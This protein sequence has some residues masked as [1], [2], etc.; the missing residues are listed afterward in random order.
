MEPESTTLST[1]GPPAPLPEE[2]ERLA[3]ARGLGS[4]E[5]GT[6]DDHPVSSALQVAVVA[7]LLLGAAAV[8]DWLA[9]SLDVRALA[10]V[11]AVFLVG[12]LVVLGFGVVAL[13]SGRR[14]TYLFSR[15]L[16]WTYRR[17]IEAATWA[18]VDRLTTVVGLP[19]HQVPKAGTILTIDGREAFVEFGEAAAEF[20]DRLV[21]AVRA[22]N[23]P[24]R[25][26]VSTT[27]GRAPEESWAK[28]VLLS[29]VA[30][31]V[32][33]PAVLYLLL[34]LY[35]AAGLPFEVALYLTFATSTLAAV[36]FRRVRI[37]AAILAGLAGLFLIIEVNRWSDGGVLVVTAVVIA[38]EITT[39]VAWRQLAR[40][41]PAPRRL[42]S[43]RRLARKRGWPYQDVADVP[44]PGPRSTH[45][46]IGVPTAATATTGE[47]VL[48][49]TANGFECRV[50]D[51]A[52]GR[53]RLGDPIRTV[54]QVTLPV[55]L[56]EY[57]LSHY[58]SWEDPPW[59]TIGGASQ[60]ARILTDAYRD[61]PVP[62]HPWWWVEGRYLCSWT[63]VHASPRVI[64]RRMDYLTRIAAGVPWEQLA[65]PA[66]WRTDQPSAEPL[67]PWDA[68]V[69]SARIR[70][71]LRLAASEVAPGSVLTT[72][73]VFDALARVDLALDWQR[74]WLQTGA[75]ET[76]GLATAPDPEGGE[77]P[78]LPESPTGPKLSA[79]LSRA[80]SVAEKIRIHY[81]HPAVTTGMVALGLVA[82]RGAGATEALLSGGQVDHAQLLSQIQAD[83]VGGRFEG[84]RAIIPAAPD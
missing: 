27:G 40:R 64:V 29:S 38:A 24:I 73:R 25:P 74:L 15:G 32:V 56:P 28:G 34:A 70:D 18:E 63:D 10:W 6:V 23:R 77:T 19:P 11:S 65:D 53:P 26:D 42:G 21:A 52:R 57:H 78:G 16:V 4:Y 54:W 82:F 3:A 72:G 67:P 62:V 5:L 68:A 75:P 43:R 46:L 20:R 58:P 35:D 33:L 31:L 55:S 13:V 7:A 49:T 17:R 37:A 84:L 80:L 81:G 83:I 47:G 48:V 76:V 22:A 8:L 59:T 41:L 79:Q 39:I 1:D 12:A 51:L 14:G 2:V 9:G 30:S 71:A 45:E 61:V 44:V 66:M 69:L 36:L 50:Y 60:A